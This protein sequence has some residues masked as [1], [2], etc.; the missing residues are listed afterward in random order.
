GPALCS[1]VNYNISHTKLHEMRTPELSNSGLRSLPNILAT[2][3]QPTL[4]HYYT[5]RNLGAYLEISNQLPQL[6]LN[7]VYVE[8]LEKIDLY[9]VRF[10]QEAQ[11]KQLSTSSIH[12][13]AFVSW[14][15]M[16]Y[17]LFTISTRET[18]AVRNCPE[19]IRRQRTAPE[20]TTMSS[21]AA[22]TAHGSA[23]SQDIGRQVHGRL[24]SISPL[25]LLTSVQIVMSGVG[26]LDDLYPAR[27]IVQAVL[28]PVLQPEEGI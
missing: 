19:S 1:Q 24:F 8:G 3:F 10:F 21:L 5:A 12:G 17:N 23:Y 18:L 28:Q 6:Y 11:F 27:D 2:D 4:F 13:T 20:D 9:G 15:E 22:Q 25:K 14:S 26:S 16:Y 7:H